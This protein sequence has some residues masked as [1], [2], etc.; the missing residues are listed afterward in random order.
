LELRYVYR[1]VE[2]RIGIVLDIED[3]PHASLTRNL[4]MFLRE[5]KDIA[6]HTALNAT[7]VAALAGN[8]SIDVQKV[9]LRIADIL[10]RTFYNT[11]PYSKATKDD[12]S[13]L[14]K[15][16]KYFEK[17]RQINERNKKK[18]EEEKAK[19]ESIKESEKP[20]T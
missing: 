18:A 10:D 7:C 14:S 13:D 12:E 3:S 19:E 15:Y 20:S 8:P 11:F 17:L 6:Q 2:D 1:R 16:D 4:R 9:G 5:M